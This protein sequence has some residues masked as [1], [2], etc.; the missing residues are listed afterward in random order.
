VFADDG[1]VA[2]RSL[3]LAAILGIPGSSLPPLESLSA[4]ASRDDIRQWTERAASLVMDSSA[5]T[6]RRID[7]HDITSRAGFLRYAAERIFGSGEIERKITTGDTE[8][9][10]GNLKDGAD[11]PVNSKRALAY[12]IQAKMWYA[13]PDNT[14]RPNDPIRRVDAL[15]WLARWVERARPE[16]FRSGLLGDANGD[17]P[18]NRISVRSGTRN[19]QLGLTEDVR[20]F[21]LVDGRSTSV[22]VLNVVGN[23]R[24]R[25]HVNTAGAIDF[26]EVELTSTGTASDRFSPVA[27][28]ETT[29]LRSTI[30][31]KVKALAGN[32]GEFRDLRPARLGTSG[33]AVRVEIIGSR[34][35]AVVNG[36]K[37]RNAL[38]LRDTLFTI[39]RE[40]SPS[41]S[42]ERF[43]FR[44]RGWGHGVGLCQVGAYGMAR[45]GRSFE[46]IL[47]TYYQ[48]VELRKAY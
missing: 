6:S 3:E 11:L 27:T 15:S 13:Y 23:E 28:W 5:P 40:V 36:Y 19:Y 12:L 18:G 33:R 4:G 10:I 31:E 20:L 8:Y 38:G 46:E 42:V 25:Y 39:S 29:L 30:A 1:T 26:L 43:T 14:A 41:G 32:V 34:G 44:G 35:S 2:N 9:Y 24:L 45:A 21:K 16:L 48:G 47:K 7:D 37:L 22:E 17:D